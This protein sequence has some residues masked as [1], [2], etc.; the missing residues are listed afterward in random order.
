MVVMNWIKKRAPANLRTRFN[1]SL[2]SRAQ[3]AKRHLS[4]QGVEIGAMQYPLMPHRKMKV[5]YVD[6]TSLEDNLSRFSELRD[7]KLVRPDYIEDGFTLTSF[8]SNSQDFVIANHV[9]EHSPNPLRALANW[10]RVLRAGG[11]LLLTV[12]V[13]EACFDRGR[14]ETT[15]EH[16]RGDYF[17]DSQLL[18]QRNFEHYMEWLAISEPAI[19]ALNG[20]NPVMESESQR[21][22]RA[23]EMCRNN[24]EIHF[25][26]FSASSFH[27][28]L[29]LFCT[30][31]DK[32]F[33]VAEV[34]DIGREVITVI[35]RVREEPSDFG[36]V[37]QQVMTRH[38]DGP[39]LVHA[40]KQSRVT[41]Y[42]I[43]GREEGMGTAAGGGAAE[44]SGG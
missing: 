6:N 23:R 4:G 39:R 36:S 42:G 43:P 24:V 17:A 35:T 32:R 29:E 41:E 26:T 15:L 9:L 8:A 21:R 14:H 18:S 7:R 22:E 31:F 28:F 5:K 3:M 30:E 38:S 1:R 27:R 19:H 20:K 34:C 44:K 40:L 12:P 10:A 13:A 16:L 37:H 2:Y 33:D 25:H 11:S